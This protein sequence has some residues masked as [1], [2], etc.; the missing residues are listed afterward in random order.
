VALAD[1]GKGVDPREY[2]SALYN[3]KLMIVPADTTSPGG[4]DVIE[5]VGVHW[6]RGKTA[7]PEE[8]NNSM[9]KYES[10]P[11]NA[12]DSDGALDADGALKAK[13]TMMRLFQHLFLK[14]LKPNELTDSLTGAQFYWDKGKNVDPEETEIGMANDEPGPSRIDLRVDDHGEL[15]FREQDIFELC[16]SRIDL[17]YRSGIHQKETFTVESFI[18]QR[19]WFPKISPYRLTVLLTPVA[20][21]TAKAVFSQKGSVTTSITLDWIYG[22]VIFLV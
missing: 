17:H 18:H 20:I 5:L 10:R 16:P 8:T 4:S 14:S 2:G 7:D 6:N 9:A 3:P 12:L 21:G 11:C 22:V 1:K 15:S 19:G 13:A